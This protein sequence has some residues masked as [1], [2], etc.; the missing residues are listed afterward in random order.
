MR[1]TCRHIGILT[2]LLMVASC[3]FPKKQAN[4]NH[5]EDMNLNVKLV[6]LDP[7]HFHA[8]LLQKNP[9]VAV[10]ETIRVYAPEG[11]EVKQYLNDINSYNQR[12]ENPTSWKEE[13][14]IG[15]DYL[16]KILSDRQ[17]DVV[18]LAGNNQ[19]KTDYILEAIKAG[20]NVLSDKPLAINK[21]DFDMLIKAY[22]LA[23]ER[24]LFIY[25]L[26]T[27]R[28]DILNIV[29]KALLKNRDL[30]GELQ[31][32]S[33]D[34]PSVYMESVHHFFKNVSGKPLIRPVWYYDTEQQGE[35]IVDVAT[36]LIDLVNWQCFYDEPIRYQSDVKVLE[37]RHWPTRITLP[38]FSQSTQVDTFPAFLNKYI[39]NGVLEVL[40]NGSL[41]YMVKGIH[42]SMKVIWNYT[43]PSDGGDTFASIKK[44]SKAT[45]KTI[46]DKESGFV[47]QLYIQRP[48]D[49]DHSEFES[50]LQK[51]IKQLQK[52]YPFLSIKNKNEGLYLIDIPQAERLEHEDHFSKVIESFLDYLHNKNMPEG[53]NENII[54]KYYITTTAV[55]LAKRE[56]QE[57]SQTHVKK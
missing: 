14:Y 44:G 3:S 18:V 43:P 20:Y 42:I 28:Y 27:E 41:N 57:M 47:K 21:K 26:M 13:I 10:N 2:V 19:R 22:Q 9:L 35:G 34:D 39:K 55:E 24:E 25:D 30:F 54:S 11:S 45:L 17:G 4:S 49:S 23:Q 5:N 38:E 56:K 1:Y 48:A 36:H 6:V 50:Q 51:A 15:R 31:K 12:A 53:E 29:E 46:Q 37:A 16:S 8:S 7:G 40:A 52:A 33:L 32:G